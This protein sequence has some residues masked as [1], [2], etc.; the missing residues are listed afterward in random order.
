MGV[1]LIFIIVVIFWSTRDEVLE[2]IQMAVVVAR[3]QSH[4]F[5][6]RFTLTSSGL[7]GNPLHWTWPQPY[8]SYF[9]DSQTRQPIKARQNLL[10][11]NP[12]ALHLGIRQ[13]SSKCGHG[14]QS[15]RSTS[16]TRVLMNWKFGARTNNLCFKRPS[17]W[18]WC[19]LKLRITGQLESDV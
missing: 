16:P 8:H 2:K 19:M 13:R 4:Y 18:F 7:S 6:L 14:T 1:I 15:I 10:K 5:S 11:I 3:S 9:S 17:K 12:Q